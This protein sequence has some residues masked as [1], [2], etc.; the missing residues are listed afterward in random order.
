MLSE[1]FSRRDRSS[2][3]KE[4][5]GGV[6]VV[7]E[8]FRANN[9]AAGG[10]VSPNTAMQN[11]A[12]WACVRVLS[13]TVASLPL[14]IYE[15]NGRVKTRAQ[16]HY[17]YGLL[18][19]QP[20]DTMTAFEFRELLM[21]H[22]LLWGNAYAQASTDARGR[23]TALYPLRPDR[24]LE[25][26]SGTDGKLFHYQP[27]NSPARWLTD[28]EVWHIPGMGGN[29]VTGYSPIAMMRRS[30]GLSNSAEA[31]GMRF[32]ENDARPGIVLE[33]PQKLGKQA[34]ENLRDSWAENH[35]GV[36][37]SHKPAILEE[38]MKLHEVGIPP[39]DA[40]FL[41]TRKFQI[42]EIARIFRVPPHLIGDLDKATFS[43]IEQQSLEF[44]IHT[45]RPWLVRWEQSIHANLMLAG[46]QP[47]YY[48]EFL[49]DGLLRGDIT[50]RYSAYA[51]GRQNGW[52]SANDIREKENENPVDG[53]DVY[54]VPLNMIPADQVGDL[55][56]S[57]EGRSVS[58]ETGE[59]KIL[60]S[61]QDDKI[62][63]VRWA[64]MDAET[65]EMRSKRSAAMRHRLQ[66]SYRRVIKDLAARMMRRE[67][68]DV[69]D[70]ARKWLKTRATSD[71]QRWLA[72]FYEDHK[73]YIERQMAPAM[74]AYG[75]M[76]ATEAANEIA[77]EM[78]DEEIER[79]MR[80]YVRTYAGRHAGNH[81]KRLM[82][83]VQQALNEGQDVLEAIEAELDAM[84]TNLPDDIANE[85]SVRANNAAAKL[86]YELNAISTLQW[87][88][89][90]ENCPYCSNLDGTTVSI[91]SNF[92]DEGQAFQPDGADTPLAP[93]RDVGH[94]P[95][96]TGCDCMITAG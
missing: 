6:E 83:L 86:I 1:L 5:R 95:A 26:R 24:M 42:N 65:R 90:G 84:E 58:T 9:A 27:E 23:V 78:K 60:R 79:F 15:R 34:Y 11:A 33:H 82:E 35:Q 48:A 59:K 18:H 71:F 72:D 57:T 96:H 69:K 52:L 8:A 12:V 63:E 14:I 19:D 93:G 31:F 51:M 94:P 20:N 92:I 41:E 55:P 2:Q 37:K 16:N 61:A 43:N 73:G 21:S 3:K 74:Q 53:G 81:E 29:G 54:L 38:G 76:V 49:V 17:L 22:L 75:E 10:Y 45:V 77:G 87:T 28:A 64:D 68:H 70:A 50:A 85:E 80:A 67:V 62:G 36:E 47:R 44:V 25:V 88:S 66:R 56:G 30:I 4:E 39:E 46:E 32:F 40:Q 13:E 89:F 91:S 7:M